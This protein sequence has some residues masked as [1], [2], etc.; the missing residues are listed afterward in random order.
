ML[1]AA[2][3][4]LST[5]LA[6]LTTRGRSRSRGNR[7][8][9]SQLAP[10]TLTL[11][12]LPAGFRPTFASAFAAAAAAGEQTENSVTL[13]LAFEDGAMT[14]WDAS[15]ASLFAAQPRQLSSVR[16]IDN[17]E[18]GTSFLSF[19]FCAT[20]N[21]AA[22]GA[23]KGYAVVVDV[24]TGAVRARLHQ[25]N[26][27]VV[28]RVALS[29][30]GDRA[31]TSTPHS[32]SVWDLTQT[33]AAD[34]ELRAPL[35]ASFP[36]D[37]DDVRTMALSPNGRL[38]AMDVADNNIAVCDV[39]SLPGTRMFVLSGHSEAVRVLS[40]T[41]YNAS[42]VSGADDGTVRVW[43]LSS[44]TASREM[45]TSAF[46]GG[47][48]FVS[49]VAIST[50]ASLVVAST[51]H[52]TLPDL[53]ID[54]FNLHNGH[55]LCTFQATGSNPTLRFS[56]RDNKSFVLT[57]NSDSDSAGGGVRLFRGSWNVEC[58]TLALLG[59]PLAERTFFHVRKGFFDKD[60]DRAIWSR[61]VGF[62]LWMRE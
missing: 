40:F 56:P 12:V 11:N 53:A 46:G 26:H 15:P 28:L 4:W 35:V 21:A 1:R 60:G 49:S 51:S 29:D 45:R 10:S 47:E 23:L 9:H 31:A 6:R 2:L 3:S 52:P 20:T 44:R 27:D 7:K 43:D 18:T 57:S 17:E 62:M 48:C 55:L 59:R 39:E 38:V 22:F 42:L 41:S 58:A 37:P 24:A 54:V 36:R 25:P 34:T 14:T 16:I 5:L 13:V 19:S 8:P 32:V 61:V 33:Q 30:A 50:D